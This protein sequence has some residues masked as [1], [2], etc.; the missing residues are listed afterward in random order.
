[1]KCKLTVDN[2][3]VAEG[4]IIAT[5]GVIH[6]KELGIS[7]YRVSVDKIIIGEAQFPIPIPDEM[8]IVQDAKGAHVAWPR[9][10]V[11]LTDSEV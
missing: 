1:M 3:I 6:G 2:K 11:I 4:H 7:N 8:T 10:F 9:N 5:S